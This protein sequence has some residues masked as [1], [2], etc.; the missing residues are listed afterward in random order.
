MKTFCNHY[1]RKEASDYDWSLIH[2]IGYLPSMLPN[3]VSPKNFMHKLEVQKVRRNGEECVESRRP[4][5]RERLS[6][7]ASL[8]ILVPYPVG[9]ARHIRARNLLLKGS[10]SLFLLLS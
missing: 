5:L 8:G 10:S 2:L 4:V 3:Y 7:R 6:S 9:Q 1:R